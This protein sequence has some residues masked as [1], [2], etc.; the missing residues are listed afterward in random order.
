MMYKMYI[1]ALQREHGVRSLDEK[2]RDSFI[3]EPTL[4]WEVFCQELD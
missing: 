4:E 2:H 1:M 3:L